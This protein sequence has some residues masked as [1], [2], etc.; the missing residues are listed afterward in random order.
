MLFLPAL[1]NT[2]SSG[3]QGVAPA[4]NLGADLQAAKAQPQTLRLLVDTDPGV[5]G[6]VALTWLVSQREQPLQILGV[7]SVA[8]NTT[9]ANAT[10]NALLVL[11]QLGHQDVPVVMGAASPLVQPLTK[12]SYFVHGPDGLW[13]LGWQNPQDLS[14]VRSDA[15][16]FYCATIAA[17]PGL[18]LLAL[19]PLTNIALAVQQCPDTMK[20]VGELVILGGAK[21]GGNKTVVAEFNFWQDPEAAN[22]VLDA[23]AADHTR[24]A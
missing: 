15:P 1:S 11:K 6:S 17:N 13:F 24:A 9:V 12:T 2:A 19:G 23:R 14:S 7:V 21:F 8:G 16:A 18:R 4:D 20:T 5:D 10:N 3:S 22:I